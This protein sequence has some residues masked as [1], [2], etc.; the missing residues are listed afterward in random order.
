MNFQEAARNVYSL[1]ACLPLGGIEIIVIIF[2]ACFALCA[3]FTRQ[4]QALRRF[5]VLTLLVL[6]IIADIIYG[7]WLRAG[8]FES[9]TISVYD[10]L[11]M[12][13]LLILAIY[14]F[15][16]RMSGAPEHIKFLDNISDELH[17]SLTAAIQKEPVKTW[18]IGQLKFLWN[19][20]DIWG[21]VR[22]RKRD[23]LVASLMPTAM[24]TK[25]TSPDDEKQIIRNAYLT[26]ANIVQ[27]AE[28]L[29]TIDDAGEIIGDEPE[30]LADRTSQTGQRR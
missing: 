22:E 25:Q 12:L 30:S 13:A 17:H 18:F 2:I 8:I 7:L 21:M 28:D 26:A 23:R 29:R 10:T 5:P 20:F 9:K 27:T 4:N 16:D 15:R 24:S 14:R 3:M 19:Y 11:L 6:L 1:M